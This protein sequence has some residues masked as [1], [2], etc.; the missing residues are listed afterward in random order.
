MLTKAKI[1][2]VYK[3]KYKPKLSVR[4]SNMNLKMTDD[5]LSIPLFY[6]EHLDAI[7]RTALNKTS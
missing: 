3:E 4:L 6:A 5:L 1:L 7:I 2:A